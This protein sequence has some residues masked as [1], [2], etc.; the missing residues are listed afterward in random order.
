MEK[1][2]RWHIEEPKEFPY[3]PAR[4][5]YRIVN[6]RGD[7]VAIVGQNMAELMV[8]APELELKIRELEQA[9]QIARGNE[10][11]TDR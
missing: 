11:I 10:N 2:E 1:P 3:G 5:P 9:L 7:S 8:S 6:D 4:F